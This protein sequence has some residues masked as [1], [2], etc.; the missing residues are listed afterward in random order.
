[1]RHENN[2][3]D[4]CCASATGFVWPKWLLADLIA[5][6]TCAQRKRI[7]K[8]VRKHAGAKPA[9]PRLRRQRARTMR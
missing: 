7:T 3:P 8:G 6:P 2:V 1:V 4:T 5:A 9:L